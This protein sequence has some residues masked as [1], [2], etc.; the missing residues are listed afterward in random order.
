[1]ID[2]D[3][4]QHLLRNYT[5]HFCT[6]KRSKKGGRNN[7]CLPLFSRICKTFE[8]GVILY[9]DRKCFNTEEDIILPFDT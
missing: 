8:Y 5:C 6:A 3:L 7:N 1:M 4:S 2:V 9:I